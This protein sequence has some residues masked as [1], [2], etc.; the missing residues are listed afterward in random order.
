[1]E[2][3]NLQMFLRTILTQPVHCHHN[4]SKEVTKGRQRYKSLPW[5]IP[6]NTK[7]PK[8]IFFSSNL[9]PVFKLSS[10]PPFSIF[11]SFSNFLSPPSPFFHS[12]PVSKILLSV[13]K[14]IQAHTGFEILTGKLRYYNIL[15]C[16]RS[17]LYYNYLN[18]FLIFSLLQYGNATDAHRSSPVLQAIYATDCMNVVFLILRLNSIFFFSTYEFILPFSYNKRSHI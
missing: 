10:H 17:G 4:L 9:L 14:K 6:I 15:I 8:L 13:W 18:T 5:L 3:I 1:M 12:R 7:P 2:H 11:F 16:Y